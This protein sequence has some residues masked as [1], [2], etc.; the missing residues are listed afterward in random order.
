MSGRVT[1]CIRHLLLSEF[2]KLGNPHPSPFH[3][4]RVTQ[5]ARWSA[6]RA[7][8]GSSLE[9]L[10]LVMAVPGPIC[11]ES[12][13][14]CPVTSPGSTPTSALMSQA[15]CSSPP[16]DWI[17]TAATLVLVCQIQL[18]HPQ[19]SL[20]PRLLILP[21]LNHQP[22][23]LQP[24]LRLKLLAQRWKP[25]LHPPLAQALNVSSLTTIVSFR[26]IL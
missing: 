5:E 14:E 17:P 20:L 9:L 3:L 23:R 19:Q 11:Q 1:D 4:V 26:A 24:E 16:V 8:S 13:P 10:V 2:H 6:S 12:T 18:L 22:P 25:H 15:L 7:T 21:Q